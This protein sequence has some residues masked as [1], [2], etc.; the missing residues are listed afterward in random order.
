MGQFRHLQ[1]E[2]DNVSHELTIRMNSGLAT[3]ANFLRGYLSFLEVEALE[4]EGGVEIADIDPTA[5][6]GLERITGFLSGKS[7]VELRRHAVDTFAEAER[8]LVSPEET[9]KAL[10]LMADVRR[11]I[12]L[13]FLEE[14]ARS[15]RLKRVATLGVLLVGIGSIAQLLDFV[16]SVD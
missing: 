3:L 14:V 8:S 15:Q 1:D 2:L 4:A 5:R 16:L 7:I 12:E 9:K 6:A 11:R 10:D 13:R